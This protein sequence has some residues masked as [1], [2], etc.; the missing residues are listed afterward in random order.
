MGAIAG[1]FYPAAPKPVDPA[2]VIAMAQAMAHRGPDG[3]GSWAGMGIG[4]A[5]RRSARVDPAAS[6]QPMLTADGRYAIVLDGGLYNGSALR[7]ELATA[8]GTMV[9]DGDAG[10]LLRCFAE[11]GP[12]MLERLDGAFAMAIH[13]AATQTLFLA[14]DRMGVKPLHVA[15]LP[16][17]ALIFASE[18]KGLLAHPLMRRL[19]D[20]RAVEDYLSAGYVPEDACV[21]AGVRKLPAGHFMLVERGRPMRA[22]RRWWQARPAATPRQVAPAD[23][24]LLA[25][26]RDAVR[27]QATAAVPAG[28]MLSPDPADAAVV[29]LMAEASPHAVR[30]C[31]LDIGDGAGTAVAAVAR[32]FATDHHIGQARPDP[33][34]LLPALPLAFDEP[35]G[36]PAAVVALCAARH[37]HAHMAV[38][39]AGSGASEL[40]ES[41]RRHLRPARWRTLMPVF[42]RRASRDID[43]LWS[44]EGR[45]A[46]SGYR[47]EDRCADLL[48]GTDPEG[49][50]DRAFELD[51][52]TGL[53]AQ[54]LTRLDRIGMAEGVELR[55]PWLD[56]RV[57]TVIASL[58]PSRRVRD[59]R[60]R[61]VIERAMAH[62]LP[63]G[64]PPRPAGRMLP[65]DDW[66]REA[67]ADQLALLPRSHIFNDLGWFDPARIAA[68]VDAHRSGRAEHGRRLWQLLML[69]RSLTR[70]F[71]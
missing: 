27:A 63:A 65:L 34:A 49:A 66:F 52:A 37:A 57:V 17:G 70:L 54:V 33:L 48:R 7:G 10:L 29:A 36:D 50:A 41:G 19:P 42:G 22:P 51:L 28:A 31:T 67:L 11:W 8:D 64:V 60:G 14:R 5:H 32:R 12:S 26:M 46:L 30:T 3:A 38:A 55:A 6:A 21:V 59:R 9:A 44:E 15:E 24:L 56:H 62:H 18:L 40:A 58:P 71:G 61:T 1:L 69:E 23:T 68:V 13:D 4:L 39:L 53:P 2:R 16:D 47:A 43:G 35:C 45:R 20:V 25:A